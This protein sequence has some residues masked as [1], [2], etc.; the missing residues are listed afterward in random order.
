MAILT[1]LLTSALDRSAIFLTVLAGRTVKI[2][3]VREVPGSNP[4]GPNQKLHRSITTTQTPTEGRTDL[5]VEI[6]I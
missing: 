5:K 3:A 4:G 1:P 2:G 6:F